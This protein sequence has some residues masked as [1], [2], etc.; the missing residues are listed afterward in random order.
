M[1]LNLIHKSSWIV[2]GKSGNLDKAD[3]MYP[4]SGKANF[5]SKLTLHHSHVCSSVYASVWF[6]RMTFDFLKEIGLDGVTA[7]FHC[8]FSSGYTAVNINTATTWPTTRNITVGKKNNRSP[9]TWALGQGRQDPS[10]T[11]AH[12]FP[13]PTSSAPSPSNNGS[14]QRQTKQ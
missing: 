5:D 3:E 2:A 6:V 8:F 14:W 12:S 1:W 10:R 11:K 9:H 4:S 7:A 13:R